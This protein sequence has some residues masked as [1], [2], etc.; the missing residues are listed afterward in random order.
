M[1]CCIIVIFYILVIE[2]IAFMKILFLMNVVSD[3]DH[4]HDEKKCIFPYFVQ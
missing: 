1:Y 4:E 2:E 3:L